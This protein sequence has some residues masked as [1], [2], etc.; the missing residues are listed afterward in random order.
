MDDSE[1]SLLRVLMDE[2][3]GREADSEC[4]TEETA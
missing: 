1:I 3:F 2:I 4:V